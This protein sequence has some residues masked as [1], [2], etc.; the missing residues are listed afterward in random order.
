MIADQL[1][2]LEPR[3]SVAFKGG[4][5]PE[6]TNKPLDSRKTGLSE[7]DLCCVGQEEKLGSGRG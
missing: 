3:D 5:A 1:K 4:Y 7:W 6:S 2:H